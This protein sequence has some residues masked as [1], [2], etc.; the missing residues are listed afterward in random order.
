[1]KP[2]S[3]KIAVTYY[4]GSEKKLDAAIYLPFK[5]AIIQSLKN[6][7]G[8]TYTEITGDVTRIIRMKMPSFKGSI[9]WYTVSVLHDLQARGITESF[10][11]KGKKINRLRD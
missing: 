1:M 11:Q 5:S 2:A 4:T 3:K 9:P 6:S 7:K 8:K 10:N